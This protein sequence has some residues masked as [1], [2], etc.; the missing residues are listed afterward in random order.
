MQQA[1]QAKLSLLPYEG[2]EMGIGQ[3]AAFTPQPQSICGWGVKA[4]WLDKRARAWHW[5]VSQCDP[6]LTRAI[7][8]RFTKFCLLDNA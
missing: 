3:S 7:P 1:T 8:E 5:Q 4:A 2:R 6:S